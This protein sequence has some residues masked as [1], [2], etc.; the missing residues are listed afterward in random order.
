LDA[1]TISPIRSGHLGGTGNYLFQ[2][3]GGLFGDPGADLGLLDG[4]LDHLY[5]AEFRQEL[6]LLDHRSAFF[7]TWLKSSIGAY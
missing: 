4:A 3:I 1:E 7:M 6:W 2:G 5:T